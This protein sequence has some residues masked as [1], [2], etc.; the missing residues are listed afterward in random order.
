MHTARV[1]WMSVLAAAGAASPCFAQAPGAPASPKPAAAEVRSSTA[2]ATAESLYSVGKMRD[3]FTK[4][5]EGGAAPAGGCKDED[6]SIHQLTLKAMMKDPK[7]DFA[8]LSDSCG[9]NF[10]FSAGRLYKN[11]VLKRNLVAGVSGKMGIGQKTLTLQTA[12]KDVQV[13]RLGEEE[14]KESP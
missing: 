10:I 2:A 11:A 6:F 13:L 3:P 5:A 8:L 4:A 9:K 12:E 1:A 14:E 7:A